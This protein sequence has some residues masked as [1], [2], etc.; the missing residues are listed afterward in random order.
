MVVI[1][2]AIFFIRIF[3]GDDFIKRIALD[4]LLPV[5]IVIIARMIIKKISVYIFTKR[6]TKI[7]ALDNFR[8]Y[9]VFLFFM[10]FFD[11]FLGILSAFI[12]LV[13][14]VLAA[15]FML[16]SNFFTIRYLNITI[17]NFYSNKG[18]SY[19]VFGRQLEAF[20]NAARCYTGFLLMESCNLIFI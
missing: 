16:S 7:L 6:N 15:V 5:L 19:S 8:A 17:L 11:C 12:R 1:G 18:I 2:L 4:K 20:D 3:L 9:N 13:K 10:F 14:A